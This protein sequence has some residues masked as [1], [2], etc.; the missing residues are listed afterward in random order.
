[1]GEGSDRFRCG[2]CIL[3]RETDE[4]GQI[5][6]VKPVTVVE[7]SETQ[8]VLWLPMDTPTKNPVLLNHTPG[9]P[10]R[11]TEDNWTL[12]DSTW[13]WGELLIVIRPDQHRATCVIWSR[14]R[15]FSGWYVNMQSRLTRTPLGFDLR[16]HQL[17]ILV[18]PNREWRWKDK[19]EL[20]ICVQDGRV[21]LEDAIAI[22]AEGQ[23]AVEEIERNVGP[24]SAGWE[25]WHPDPK[26]PRP[27]LSSDWDDLS[28]YS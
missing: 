23:R 27:T 18:E 7:D 2:D 21:S 12:Q 6:D 3:Y 9:T 25:G 16:D 26:L 8:I 15:E 19:D 5:I 11:W 14:D 24:F 1:M 13:Q 22:R 17:D 20:D 28:M 4:H 10:R